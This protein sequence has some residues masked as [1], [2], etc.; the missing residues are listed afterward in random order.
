MRAHGR[1]FRREHFTAWGFVPM[2]N[3]M[4]GVTIMMAAW[5]MGLGRTS[6]YRWRSLDRLGSRVGGLSL[7]VFGIR[8]LSGLT[9][10]FIPGVITSRGNWVWDT[11]MTWPRQ[12]SSA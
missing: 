11:P 10:I 1:R 12:P 5:V 2:G 3:F 6:F 9:A 7:P 4:P 8:S